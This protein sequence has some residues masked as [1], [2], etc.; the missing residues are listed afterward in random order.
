MYEI[1]TISQQFDWIKSVY[2]GE[3]GFFRYNRGKDIAV[4]STGDF[5]RQ[6]I[7]ST[8]GRLVFETINN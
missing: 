8:K 3:Q 6:V 2:A 4:D 7:F 5:L 1:A